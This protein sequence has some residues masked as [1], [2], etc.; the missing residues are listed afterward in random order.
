MG[1]S[2]APRRM[3]SARRHLWLWP[4]AHRAAVSAAI[5]AAAVSLLA[6]ACGPA[7]VA[8][9][10][11][12]PSVG[13][14]HGRAESVRI[15][16]SATVTRATDD[17]SAPVVGSVAG[18]MS[19]Q[20]RLDVV[21]RLHR[22]ASA[23]VAPDA[24]P[25]ARPIP[26]DPSHAFVEYDDTVTRGALAALFGSDAAATAFVF[27]AY[28]VRG[29]HQS[30]APHAVRGLTAVVSHTRV[31]RR[32]QWLLRAMIALSQSACLESRTC[33]CSSW[34]CPVDCPRSRPGELSLDAMA[35]HRLPLC[36][37]PW[38]SYGGRSLA[39]QRFW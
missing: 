30:R 22:H 32:A 10:V 8:A 33:H 19:A 24:R 20:R 29:D 2:M 38:K 35:Q 28:G 26:S 36:P 6:A 15:D 4:C 18:D 3:A 1:A 34:P 25:E 21:A 9:C 11:A 5:V 31:A 14:P 39:V 17:V 13:T 27:G 12:S 16:S 37:A 7:S 23:G